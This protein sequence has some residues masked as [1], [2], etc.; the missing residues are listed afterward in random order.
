MDALHSLYQ[1]ASHGTSL[2]LTLLDGIHQQSYAPSVHRNHCPAPNPAPYYC[3]LSAHSS[4]PSTYPLSVF[5][6]PVFCSPLLPPPVSPVST[7]HSPVNHSSCLLSA[8][9][10]LSIFLPCCVL[11]AHTFL[12]KIHGRS[13]GAMKKLTIHTLF[14]NQERG[15]IKTQN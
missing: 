10:P 3:L 14:E 15:F 7:C 11:D 5:T 4:H 1:N 8:H 13:E 2:V 12:P 9:T 6:V